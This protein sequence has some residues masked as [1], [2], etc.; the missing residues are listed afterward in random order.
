MT[1]LITLVVL[2]A[3]IIFTALQVD[4]HCVSSSYDAVCIVA[5]F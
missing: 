1:R 2:F 5:A 4:V 3:D